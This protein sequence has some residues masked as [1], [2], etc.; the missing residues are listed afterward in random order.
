V[1]ESQREFALKCL[2][3]QRRLYCLPRRNRESILGKFRAGTKEKDFLKGTVDIENVKVVENE[4][5]VCE[6]GAD[7]ENL[8]VTFCRSFKTANRL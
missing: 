4:V 2:E 5:R 7:V 8:I 6:E 3:T 1:S